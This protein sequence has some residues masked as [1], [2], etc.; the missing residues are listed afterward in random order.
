MDDNSARQFILNRVVVTPQKVVVAK[1]FVLKNV[2]QQPGATGG[3]I[4]GFLRYMDAELPEEIVLPQQG[5]STGS[6]ERAA[7]SLSWQLAVGEA[8]WSLIHSSVLLPAS[9]R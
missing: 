4:D 2:G 8:I 1:A 5:G 6:L 3:I 9:A 7:E